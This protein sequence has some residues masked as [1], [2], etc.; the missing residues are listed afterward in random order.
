MLTNTSTT[1]TFTTTD[2]LTVESAT[3]TGTGWVTFD[4]YNGSF[5]PEVSKTISLLPDKVIFQD[6]K[7]TVVLKKGNKTHVVRNHDDEYDRVYG[8]LLAFFQMNSGLSKNKANKY[9][10]SLRL[11][12]KQEVRK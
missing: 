1:A 3:L 8:F 12:P 10:E 7:E 2:N 4:P 6:D 9:L 11:V 5:K